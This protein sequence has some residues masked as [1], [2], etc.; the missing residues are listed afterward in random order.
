ML[1]QLAPRR[2]GLGACAAGQ[3]QASDGSCFSLSGSV[4]ADVGT[5]IQG[6]A[7]KVNLPPSVI[8]TF[9]QY[10]GQA[11]AV[12]NDPKAYGTQLLK[13]YAN[14]YGSQYAAQYG[15][16]YSAQVGQ[17]AQ[18]INSGAG[19][20]LL[21][22][23][24]AA[25]SGRKLTK[26]EI[27]GGFM[28]AATAAAVIGGAQVPVAGPFIA[29]AALLVFGGGALVDKGLRAIF[30]P[31]S[32][33]APCSEGDKGLRGKD[34]SDPDWRTY[35]VGSDPWLP[36][37]DGAFER[38]ARPIWIAVQEKGLNCQQTGIP[39]G[40]TSC[41]FNAGL[42]AAWNAMFPGAP[43]RTIDPASIFLRHFRN[44]RY[45][46]LICP[47]ASCVIPLANTRWNSANWAMKDPGWRMQKRW[48]SDPVAIISSELYEC[49]E[50]TGIQPAKDLFGQGQNDSDVVRSL[51]TRYLPLSVAVPQTSTQKLLKTAA[52]FAAAAAVAPFAYAWVTGQ[53]V[54]AVFNQA[55]RGTV[56]IFR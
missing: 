20:A 8:P 42:I 18:Y 24:D 16:Q 45:S 9:T 5:N 49:P 31:D 11:N 55:W 30:G 12:A 7:P 48:A 52:P 54:K 25:A 37:S 46:N 35:N 15:A 33:P 29:L 32:T 28:A 41:Q 21:A 53:S 38:W 3:A 50:I 44:L 4:S 27:Q 26:E 34:P 56:S 39:K 47:D 2:V 13:Q 23:V 1:G 19:Q 10:A 36:I 43:R 17:A 22:G 40:T 51:L 6:W 14:Q